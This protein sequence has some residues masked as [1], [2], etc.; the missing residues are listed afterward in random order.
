MPNAEIA[1]ALALIGR[2]LRK[3]SGKTGEHRAAALA[4][5]ERKATRTYQCRACC[6]DTFSKAENRCADDVDAADQRGLTKRE[7]REY[8]PLPPYPRS[9]VAQFLKRLDA[10]FPKCP[11]FRVNGS[12]LKSTL[13]TKSTALHRA[14]LLCHSRLIARLVDL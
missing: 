4:H 14:F 10:A 9:Q 8:P 11:D 7:I 13:K 12:K 2:I 1:P 6:L 3:P 5:G